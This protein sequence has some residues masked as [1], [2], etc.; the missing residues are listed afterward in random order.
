MEFSL[1]KSK[2]IVVNVLSKGGVV[3]LPT[4]T[5]YALSCVI[6]NEN[7]LNKILAIKGRDISKGIPVLVPNKN[8]FYKYSNNVNKMCEKLIETFLPGALTLIMKKKSFISN[9]IS[10]DSDNIAL[11]IPNN[12]NLIK[13]MNTLNSGIT[14]T[15]ANISGKPHS[16]LKEELVKDLGDKV[17]MIVFGRY[18]E[19]NKNPSTILDLS[20]NKLEIIREGEIT[21]SDIKNAGIKVD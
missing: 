19:K 17:D 11:R 21:I 8:Y 2:N 7:S 16:L 9:I 12:K 4:D 18:T 6:T 1:D 14:G 15:S 10:G 20:N 5:I 3:V 13:I